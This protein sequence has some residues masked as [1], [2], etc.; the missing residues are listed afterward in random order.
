MPSR[1]EWE[2]AGRPEIERWSMIEMEHVEHLNRVV[3]ETGAEIVISSS[4]RGDPETP[5]ILKENGLVANIIDVTP[6]SWYI[7]E[8][9]HHSLRGEE[10]QQWLDKNISP[11]EELAYVIVDDDSDML[12]HQF[13]VHTS[14]KSGMDSSHS[15]TM[16]RLL[17]RPECLSCG[18]HLIP[19]KDEIA[20]AF[21]GYTWR[22]ECMPPELLISIG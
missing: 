21:T 20:K 8:Q 15:D 11:D 17:N 7:K 14:W 10:I 3:A 19:H 16:I 9:D 6:R 4:W 5:K 18:K 1:A 12:P 22:C 13:F 2:A